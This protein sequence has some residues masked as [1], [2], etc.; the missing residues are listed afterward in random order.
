MA[1]PAF[2]CYDIA[3]AAVGAGVR[4]ALYD[5]DPDTLGPD[6]A[7]LERVLAAGAGAVVAGPLYGVPLEWDALRA[8]ADR[9]GA[10][11]IEDAAQ[12]HGASWRGRPLGSLGDL[13]VLSFGR[14]KLAVHQREALEALADFRT[15]YLHLDAAWAA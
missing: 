14:G 3:S 2:T 13:S 10:L 15:D 1:L 12:G 8:L 5:V 6:P 7:S 4:V 11:L 9:H